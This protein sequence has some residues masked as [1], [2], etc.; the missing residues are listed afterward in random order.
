VRFDLLGSYWPPESMHFGSHIFIGRGARIAASAGFYVGNHVLIGPDL[1]VMGGDH[2]FREVGKLMWDVDVGG[3]D[4]PV[5]VEDDVWMGARVTVLKGVT[6]GC[7]SVIGA[8]SVVTKSIPQYSVAA[9]NPCRVLRPRFSDEE[10]RAHL[11]A[12]GAASPAM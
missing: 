9:G 12:L 4:L 11:T 7:G 5:V 1:C 6:I 10:L 2:N 3:V 8:G